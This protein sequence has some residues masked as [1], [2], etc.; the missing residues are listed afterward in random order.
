MLLFNSDSFILFFYRQEINKNR[1]ENARIKKAIKDFIE[2][3]QI[4]KKKAYVE[5]TIILSESINLLD[6]RINRLSKQIESAEMD[7]KQLLTLLVQP[8]EKN[9]EKGLNDVEDENKI[10][11]NDCLNDLKQ[12]I[13]AVRIIV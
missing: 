4:I 10:I 9:N 3:Y 12:Q 5:E 6:E 7:K 11:N 2:R 1:E 8:E 13:T